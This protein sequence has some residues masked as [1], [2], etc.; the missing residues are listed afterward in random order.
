[1]YVQIAANKIGNINRIFKKENN[2][3]ETEIKMIPEYSGL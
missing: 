3:L 1:M 2:R